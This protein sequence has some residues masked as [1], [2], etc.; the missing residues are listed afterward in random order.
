MVGFSRINYRSVADLNTAI[1]EKLSKIPRDLDLVVGIPRSGMLAANLIAL[2]LNLPLTDLDGF[3]NGRI[4]RSGQRQKWNV[5]RAQGLSF[6]K[7]LVVDD[8]VYSG[9][10]MREA[11]RIIEQ[12]GVS[13]RV[14]YA[15]VFLEEEAINEVDFYFEI[16]PTPRIFEWNMMHDA[17]LH[18][19]CVDID[20]VLCRDPTEEENDDGCRY[21]DF[22]LGVNP[23]IVPTV[24]IGHLVTCRL[25]KF[26]DPT[27]Q[28]LAAN[29]FKYD[30][31]VMMDLPDKAARIKAQN[32]GAYKANVYHAKNSSLFIESS[33]EQAQTILRLTGKSVFCMQT[34]QMLMPG[35]VPQ[36]RRG[37]LKI[38]P[39]MWRR[40][41]YLFDK[42]NLPW[43][44]RR[45]L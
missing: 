22:I 28:W 17:V 45:G 37:V 43:P 6:S 1:L 7:V 21:R 25:E 32:H 23:L 12:S 42:E 9:K 26:R 14:V 40:I 24:R 18:T 39:Y 11:K 13:T 29:G 8:S 20:G 31:L 15:C 44:F 27:E 3:I 19:A 34:R 16:C 35:T 2:H 38:G 41:S 5:S 30:E 36:I 10:A 33:F 4:M